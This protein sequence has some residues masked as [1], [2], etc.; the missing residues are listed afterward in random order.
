MVTEFDGIVL[1]RLFSVSAERQKQ[2]LFSI[3]SHL[4]ACWL[5]AVFFASALNKTK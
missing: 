4:Q 3:K 2:Y 5:A 1:L